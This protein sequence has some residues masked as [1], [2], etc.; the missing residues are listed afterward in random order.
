MAAD[1]GDGGSRGGGRAGGSQG[2]GCSRR[3]RGRLEPTRGD[4]LRRGD[5]VALGA[6][7]QTWMDRRWED[8]AGWRSSG[9]GGGTRQEAAR[10]V[11]TRM[12][13]VGGAGVRKRSLAWL[14]LVVAFLEELGGGSKGRKEVE[15]DKKEIEER[16]KCV[17]GESKPMEW[18]NIAP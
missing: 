3:G 18:F 7:L 6:L 15:L 14:P 9:R 16:C 2:L 11:A 1:T 17:M 13:G 4:A 8:L 10:S 5:E 12:L